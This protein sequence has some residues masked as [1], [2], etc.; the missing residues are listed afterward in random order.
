MITIAR[1]IEHCADNVR[2]AVEL[3]SQNP[4]VKVEVHDEDDGCVTFV[5]DDGSVLYIGR[6]LFMENCDA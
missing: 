3:A 1:S 6:A 5:F 2:D 4:F